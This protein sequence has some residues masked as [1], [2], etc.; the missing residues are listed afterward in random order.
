[1]PYLF[2]MVKKANYF[3]IL[4]YKNS[5]DMILSALN[6]IMIR[7]YNGYN[8]YVH[9]LAKFDIIF[10]LK[11][12]VKIATMQPIIHNGRII[13]LL[14]NYGKNNEYKIEF[15]DSYLILLASLRKLCVAF[16]VN[17]VKSIFPFL[18]INKNNLDY[19]GN[20][21]DFKYFSGISK[22]DYNEYKSEFNN[23]WN[24]KNE[25]IK[26]CNI[27]CISLYQI[28]YKLNDLIFNLFS[29]NIYHYPTLPSLAFGIFRSNFM[30]ENI[31]PQLSGK[32]AK[33]IRSGYTGGAVDMYIPE[34]KPGVK[35]NFMM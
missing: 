26:Y 20:V 1:M 8:I 14:I 31:I 23:N 13:S 19:I 5:E 6:S 33:D 7:K 21:P 4:D 11:Y 32:I 22:N 15:R 28:I 16:N 9:N 12:L 29:K 25:S 10:L 2:T 18:F 24:L 35:L 34:S 27:D 3:Y 30:S 17:T